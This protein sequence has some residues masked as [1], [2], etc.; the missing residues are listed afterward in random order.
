M[1]DHNYFVYITT[2]SKRKVLYTGITND[3]FTRMSQHF[4]GSKNDRKTFSG[5]YYCYPLIYFERF[6]YVEHAIEREKEIKGWKREK[7][8]KLINEFNPDWKFLNDEV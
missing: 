5:K 7:K 4:E 1:R 6:Q 8:E 2:N 3:L